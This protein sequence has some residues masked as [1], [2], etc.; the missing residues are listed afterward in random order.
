MEI[1]CLLFT[2]DGRKLVSTAQ[3]EHAVRIWDLLDLSTPSLK[4]HFEPCFD[5]IVSPSGHKIWIGYERE[6]KVWDIATGEQQDIPFKEPRIRF[7][8]PTFSPD[9][10]YL[11]AFDATAKRFMV[12]NGHIEIRDLAT[13]EVSTKS[14][15]HG[16]SI[17]ALSFSPDGT[18]IASRTSDSVGIV[19]ME[20]KE[21]GTLFWKYKTHLERTIFIDW[22]KLGYYTVDEKKWVTYNGERLLALPIDFWPQ[23]IV[24][25]SASSLLLQCEDNSL[26]VLQFSQEP[27]WK[28]L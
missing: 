6:P 19:D 25:I 9:D 27:D 24:A 23:W 7:L 11:V 21:R 2:P 20:R 4:N 5:V 28:D 16:E 17:Y 10:K 8:P 22:D 14:T 12:Y 18:R 15:V 3:Y 1:T 26:T 13:G